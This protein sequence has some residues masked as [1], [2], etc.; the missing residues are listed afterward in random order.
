M[1]TIIQYF[2]SKTLDFNR[3]SFYVVMGALTYVPVIISIG[4]YC[5]NESIIYP[6]LFYILSLSF[7]SGYNGARQAIAYGFAM[8]AYWCF[9]EKKEYI[10]YCIFLCIAF[11]F[12]SAVMF[13]IPFHFFST[14]KIWSKT[15]LI[16]VA[17]LLISCLFLP[18]LWEYMIIIFENLGQ[19]KMANDYSEFV[20][21][22]SGVLR[23]LV[24]LTPSVI[25]LLN[26]PKLK[27][28]FPDID[29]LIILS[30]CGGIFMVFSL[31]SAIFARM[32]G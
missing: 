30:L 17:T 13:V 11:G 31:R 28:R 6:I 32:A 2:F 29:R 26:Y 8:L 24:A 25:A 7:Y 21:K 9:F 3:L 18:A 1:F 16:V 12:H 4:V 23:S 15:F 10:K 20:D 22:G 5:K 14:T 19:S 27:K